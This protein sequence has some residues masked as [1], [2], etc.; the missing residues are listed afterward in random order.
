MKR[1]S[2]TVYLIVENLLLKKQLKAATE[3]LANE[4]AKV[5]MKCETCTVNPN[6]ITCNPPECYKQEAN[7]L[8]DER[9]KE[10][11]ER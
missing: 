1:Q 4:L 2:P 7:R 5:K 10:K 8:I 6:L 11:N 3:L 9:M